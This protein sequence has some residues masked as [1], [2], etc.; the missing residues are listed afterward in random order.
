MVAVV[1]YSVEPGIGMCIKRHA[2]KSTISEATQAIRH[3]C[4]ALL[5]AIAAPALAFV[6]VSV[7]Y[8][9]EYWERAVSPVQSDVVTTDRLSAQGA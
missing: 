8:C 6:G 5:E 4:R 3:E 7:T 9:R 2:R 1:A